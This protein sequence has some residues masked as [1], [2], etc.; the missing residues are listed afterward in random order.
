MLVLPT[1]KKWFDMI[2]SGEKKEEYRDVKPYYDSRLNKFC[3]ISTRNVMENYIPNNT[4]EVIFRNGYSK[5]SPS[6]KCLCSCWYGEG[7]V[8]WGAEPNKE[9]YILR[10][11]DVKEVSYAKNS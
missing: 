9:Y 3:H 10:I 6:I 5:S 2:L 1:K 8:D 11:L 4:F 7:K